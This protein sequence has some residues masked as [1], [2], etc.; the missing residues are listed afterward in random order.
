MGGGAF[1]LPGFCLG[2]L[3]GSYPQMPYS[4]GWLFLGRKTVAQEMRP[5]EETAAPVPG[6]RSELQSPK[7]GPSR[8]RV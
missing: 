4:E 1:L 3:K 6:V 8:S 7:L 2:R 5:A